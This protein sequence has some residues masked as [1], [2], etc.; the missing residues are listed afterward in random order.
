M[1]TAIILGATSLGL[2]GRQMLTRLLED[3]RFTEVKA[4]LRRSTHLDHPK[5]QEIIVDFNRLSSW[6]EE[7][8][9][10]EEVFQLAG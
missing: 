8:K 7:I 9:E 1:A 2:V 6:M 3:D 5:L 4:V 10:L